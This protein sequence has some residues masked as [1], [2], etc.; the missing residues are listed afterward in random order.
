MHHRIIAL[1][2]TILVP[3][4]AGTAWAKGPPPKATAAKAPVMALAK[5]VPDEVKKT[6]DAFVGRWRFEGALTQAGTTEPLRAK[7][8]FTC[9]RVA[10]GR[11]A[12]CEFKAPF[13]GSP[14]MEEAQLWAFNPEDRKVHLFAVNTAGEVH[15]H[16]GTWKDDQT[17]EFDPLK[18]T[19]DG[20]PIED[21]LVVTWEGPKMVRFDA[22]TSYPNGSIVVFRGSGKRM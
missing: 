22:V 7:F 2:V 3:L 13:P 15:D 6:V 1:L 10:G 9:R 16:A 20:K 18:T 14:P 19:D 4:A 17:L 8:V 21:S 5:A 12:A 11:A